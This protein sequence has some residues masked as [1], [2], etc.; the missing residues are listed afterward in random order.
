MLPGAVPSSQPMSHRALQRA[1]PRLA[2]STVMAVVLL[3]GLAPSTFA[4]EP[5]SSLPLT[6]DDLGLD[7]HDSFA[8]RV[9]HRPGIAVVARPGPAGPAPSATPTPS[10]T[11]P[12]RASSAQPTAVGVDISYPQ[13]GRPYPES[14]A[15]AVI[16]VNGG[17]VY[18]AN[19][20]L[21][22][23]GGLSQLAWAGRDAELYLNT[24]NPGPEDSRYWP[25][26]QTEPRTCDP[27]DED[28]FDCAY[29]YGWNAAL[30][31]HAIALEAYVD[32]D[33]VEVE[34]TSVPDDVMWWLDVE[35]ANS[36]RRDPERNVAALQGMVDGLGSVGAERIGFYSTPRLWERITGGTDAFADYPAWH[37]G[38]ADEADARTRCDADDAFTGG[39]LAMV[40]WVED[41]VDRNVRCKS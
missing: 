25:R 2:A 26:G 1:L 4:A 34:A 13:C 35:D 14:G 38:A 40:Q 9:A 15:F 3:G 16:G 27:G 6:A 24:G 33:W 12:P 37:A 7:G 31:A 19:P 36:W 17:R 32:L 21:G 20:C 30:E 23:E 39:T 22:D 29:V 8:D 41:G 18:S 11:T 28:S 10:P 5:S